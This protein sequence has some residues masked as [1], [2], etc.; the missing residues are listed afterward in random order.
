MITI[1]IETID[2]PEL[3]RFGSREKTKRLKSQG[4]MSPAY[5]QCAYLLMR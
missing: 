4:H 1:Q 5:Y 2:S 3:T